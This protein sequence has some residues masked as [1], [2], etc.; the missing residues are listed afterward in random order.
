MYI[1]RNQM[2]NITLAE[3]DLRT[4]A[5][6]VLEDLKCKA[7][8]MYP[9]LAPNRMFNK[10]RLDYTYNLE[11]AMA[12]AWMSLNTIEIEIESLMKYPERMFKEVIGHE[13][14]HL[15]VPMIYRC[16]GYKPEELHG[17]EW[18][19]VMYTMGFHIDNI[20]PWKCSICGVETCE[21]CFS[22]Y[23]VCSVCC[24]GKSQD[25]VKKMINL[26]EEDLD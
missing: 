22:Y 8:I 18:Q 12:K 14:C 17:A 3:Q 23:G 26:Y 4:H 7:V 13:L 15:L 6:E 10:I 20:S 9:Q 24:E 5:E 21:H 25:E 2:N 11:D 19:N 1:G 16:V